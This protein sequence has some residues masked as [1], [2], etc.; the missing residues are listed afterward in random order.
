MIK[1]SLLIGTCCQCLDSQIKGD[2]LTRGLTC[3]LDLVGEGGVVVSSAISANRHLSKIFWRLLGQFCQNVR[4]DLVSSLRAS[5]QTK[6]LSLNLNVHGRVHQCE[7][8]V[9]RPDPRKAWYFS[10]FAP[11]KECAHCRIQPK[12]D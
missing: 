7:K 9:A 4:I 2:H 1:S 10:C 12:V 11:P 6:R 3:F 8:A 5:G